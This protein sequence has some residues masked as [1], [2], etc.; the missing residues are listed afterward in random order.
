MPVDG[1]G[2]RLG[3]RPELDGLRAVAILLVM[4]AHAGIP[5]FHNGGTVGVTLFFVLSGFLISALLVEEFQRTRRTDLAAFYIRRARRLLP[6]LIVLIAVMVAIGGATRGDA[7]WALTYGANWQR[8][9]GGTLGYLSHTW[10]L[11]IEEQFYLLF[12]AAFIVGRRRPA[13]FVAVL[14]ALAAAAVATR[15][16]LWSGPDATTRIYF[17]SDTRADAILLGCAAGTVFTW[18]R[19][20]VPPTRVVAA[21]VAAL[22]AV[23]MAAADAFTY[24]AGLTIAAVAS[25]VLVSWVGGGGGVR[26]LRSRSMVW[27]GRASYS[28]YLWHIPVM[29]GLQRHLGYS[30]VRILLGFGLS[31][32]LAA[33]SMALI[34]SPFRHRRAARVDSVEPTADAGVAAVS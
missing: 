7:V 20:I 32:G 1:G 22:A 10:S 29:W 14:L 3:Y 16:I 15:L 13:A 28:L 21:C 12:P 4:A 33:V 6:A 27:I 26:L 18:W 5:A 34:E 19:P 30:V 11:A 23:T 9:A 2:W 24:R 25:L 17:G 31:A 8:A